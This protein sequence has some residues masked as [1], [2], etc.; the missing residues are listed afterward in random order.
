MFC[1]K[2][3][4]FLYLKYLWVAQRKISSPV[5]YN[6]VLEDYREIGMIKIQEAL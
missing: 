1:K 6:F 5:K 4:Q 2:E 3:E